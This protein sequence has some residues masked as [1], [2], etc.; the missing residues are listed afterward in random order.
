MLFSMLS[1]DASLYGNLEKCTFC[2]NRV[3]FL[4]YVVTEQGIEV[5]PAKI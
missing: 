5:N 3:A 4:G 1:R 2:T